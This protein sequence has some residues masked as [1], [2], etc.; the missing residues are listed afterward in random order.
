MKQIL[1]KIKLS[2]VAISLFVLIMLLLSIYFFVRLSRNQQDLEQR[3]FRTLNQLGVAMKEKDTV[4]RNIVKNSSDSSL[5]DQKR[6]FKKTSI[7]QSLKVSNLPISIDSLVYKMKGNDQTPKADPTSTKHPS[8]TISVS[9]VDSLSKIETSS[10][11]SVSSFK[12]SSSVAES[13]VFEEKSAKRESLCKMSIQDFVAPLLKRRDFFS[14]YVLLRNDTIVFSTFGG[15]AHL[16]KEKFKKAEIQNSMLSFSNLSNKTNE[17]SVLLIQAGFSQSVKIQGK[18]YIFFAIPLKMNSKPDWYL[19]GLIE[20]NIFLSWKRSLPFEILIYT[21]L[22]LFFVI[23]SFPV[24]KVFLSGPLEKLS[25]F[26]HTLTGL[27]LIAIP[28]LIVVLMSE[29]LLSN[30]LKQNNYN[31]LKRLNEKVTSEFKKESGLI[32]KQLKDYQNA[33]FDSIPKPVLSVLDL[34]LDQFKPFKY[35]FF[36]AFFPADSMGKQP[37]YLTPYKEGQK[38][39]VATR[40]YFLHPDKYKDTIKEDAIKN[41]DTIWYNLEPI[42]SNTSGEWII[43]FSIPAKKQNSS[44][45][46]AIT[47]SMYSLKDPVLPDGFKYCLIDQSGKIWYDSEE[48]YNLSDNLLI[49]TGNNQKLAFALKSDSHAKFKVSIRNQ[50]HLLYI[51]QVPG[52]EL[53]VV[54][55]VNP[56]RTNA[57]EA[58]TTSTVIGFFAVLYLVLLVVIG[59]IKL[60]TYKKTRLMGREYFFSWLTPKKSKILVYQTLLAIN[61]VGCVFLLILS[62]TGVFGLISVGLLSIFFLLLITGHFI[63]M[64]YFLNFYRFRQPEV[65]HDQPVCLKVYTHFIFSWL[66][67]GSIL[68]ALIMMGCF[69]AAESKIYDQNQLCGLAG[70]IN[71]RTLVLKDFFDENY[72]KNARDLLFDQRNNEGLYYEVMNFKKGESGQSLD[73]G[74][75]LGF[76]NQPYFSIIRSNYYKMMGETK[77]PVFGQN[78]KLYQVDND[79]ARMAVTFDKI[80]DPFPGTKETIRDTLISHHS[81]I[82]LYNPCTPIVGWSW[83]VV[84]FWL[85]ALLLMYLIYYLLSKMLFILF[86]YQELHFKNTDPKKLLQIVKQSEKNII[87]VSIQK[88]DKKYF[89]S[90]GYFYI[91]LADNPP[92]NFPDDKCIIILNFEKGINDPVDIEKKLQLLDVYLKHQP[93]ILLLAKTPVQLLNYYNELWKN[94]P[95]PRIYKTHLR[96]FESLV[97]ALPVFYTL[98]FRQ[99]ETFESSGQVLQKDVPAPCK[100]IEAILVAEALINPDIVKMTPFLELEFESIWSKGFC[101]DQKHLWKMDLGCR[102]ET[103]ILKIQEYS[104]SRYHAIWDSLTKN[105]QF[106]LNDLAEDSM[107]NMN[108]REIIKSLISKGILKLNDSLEIT[109]QPFRNFI[110]TDVDKTELEA[111]QK[112]IQ[113]SGNWNRLRMPLILIAASIGIFLFVTQQ[114]FLSN[115]NTY[116]ISIVTIAGTFLKFSGMFSK[117]KVD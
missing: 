114:H 7:R 64:Y 42:Y 66:L 14:H 88:A 20:E 35:R 2:G 49:E 38:S 13:V 109:S 23:F 46:I 108:N 6:G 104:R 105:E 28:V 106:V 37:L 112:T 80:S 95:N 55:L 76:L 10:K 69:T 60:A 83:G 29:I 11:K 71:E 24:L 3:G 18:D 19:G 113:L 68:P 4:I 111:M 99:E 21:I 16:S 72:N 78:L 33:D 47:S 30:R 43:A 110:L 101:D 97:S 54:T 48:I 107:V 90:Q 40:D 96:L 86:P 117:G 61:G 94:E 79:P 12:M 67:F 34:K 53:F 9:N 73:S 39:N 59:L 82:K 103:F 92:P 8:K 5:K 44:R 50:K 31:Q 65:E 98:P 52:I 100:A 22:V 58:L 62:T 17:D 77:L 1:K 91:D 87:V 41:K 26:G 116:L 115:L 45:I 85:I 70:K 36:K 51:S 93:A 15:D 27:A 25:R 32:L 74:T 102:K 84:V 56:A 75:R 57:T 81:R 63:L 89:K